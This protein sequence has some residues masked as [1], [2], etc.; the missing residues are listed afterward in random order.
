[1]K[2]HHKRKY[3][4]TWGSVAMY[5][6]TIDGVVCPGTPTEKYISTHRKLFSE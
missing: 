2:I 5:E 1:M 3:S 4:H 6:K